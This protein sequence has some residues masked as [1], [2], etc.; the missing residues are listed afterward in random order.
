MR[1]LGQVTSNPPC[2]AGLVVRWILA[3]AAVAYRSLS[4][5]MGWA[6]RSPW[7]VVEATYGWYWA[8]DV[9]EAAG[10]ELHLAHR[11]G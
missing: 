3:L 11:S 5:T 10:A 7:V 2:E 4:C 6:C 1:E 9:I 8:A